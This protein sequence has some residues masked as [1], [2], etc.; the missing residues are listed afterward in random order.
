MVS[1]LLTQWSPQGE[2]VSAGF[3]RK[4]WIWQSPTTV[5]RP[6]L[7]Q[8]G[9]SLGSEFESVAGIAADADP[10]RAE[11]VLSSAGASVRSNW[12]GLEWSRKGWPASRHLATVSEMIFTEAEAI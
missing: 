7:F 2:R 3:G 6:M 1:A 11:L 8:G 5:P 9:A 12:G 4:S 10:G